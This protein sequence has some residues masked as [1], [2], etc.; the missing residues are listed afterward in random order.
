MKHPAIKLTDALGEL[1]TLSLRPQEADTV[2]VETTIETVKNFL[3]HEM[4]VQD[5]ILSD[6]TIEGT[7]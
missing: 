3:T 2:V 7:C 5:A 4:W 1:P 6:V